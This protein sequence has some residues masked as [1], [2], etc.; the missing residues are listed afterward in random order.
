MERQ[1][2]GH[3][4]RVKEKDNKIQT[5]LS[6]IE[7]LESECQKL[8]NEFLRLQQIVE[9]NEKDTEALNIK[10]EQYKDYAKRIHI[11]GAEMDRLSAENKAL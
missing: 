1:V 9:K 2:K 6:K 3:L 8:M 5:L 7:R 11:L 10:I 4:E